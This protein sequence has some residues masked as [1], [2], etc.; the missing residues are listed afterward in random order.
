MSTILCVSCSCLFCFPHCEN[1]SRYTSATTQNASC[2]DTVSN[3]YQPGQTIF[4]AINPYL[5]LAMESG[6]DET[7]LD[8]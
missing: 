2:Q 3:L 6:V 7:I 8:W 5:H 1:I 4:T